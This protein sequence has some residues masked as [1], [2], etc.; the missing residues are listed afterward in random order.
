MQRVDAVLAGAT[1]QAFTAAV[2]RVEHRGTVVFEQ[3]YGVTRDDELSKPVYADSLFDLASITKIFVTT[4]ALRAVQE[5][6]LTLDGPVMRGAITLRMLLAHVSGMN[7]GADYRMLLG[8]NVLEYT[9]QRESSPNPGPGLFTVTWALS[10]WANC[11]SARTAV[12]CGP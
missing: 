6:R 9:A 11:S 3:A 8:H 12:R 1:G 10:R 7:S 2:A 4:L 5:K